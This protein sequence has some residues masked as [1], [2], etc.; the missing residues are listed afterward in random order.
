MTSLTLDNVL[1]CT[2]LPVLSPASV[3]LMDLT[4]DPD[5]QPD[6]VDTLLRQDPAL[7]Q[8]IVR[9]VN[10]RHF[11]PDE[12]CTTI[13]RAVTYL[14]MSPIR[15]LAAGFSLMDVTTGYADDIDLLEYWR[16]GLISAAAARYVAVVTRCCNPQDAFIAALMQ[17]IGML[18]LQTVVGGAYRDVLGGTDGNHR[19]LPRHERTVLGMTHAEAG[20]ALARQWKLPERMIEPI[21]RHHHRHA[22]ATINIPIVNAVVLGCQ[23]SHLCMG[24]MRKPD[25]ARAGAMSRRFF[26]LSSGDARMLLAGAAQDA[27][28]LAAGL[29][30]MGEGL[31]DPDVIMTRAS[32]AIV[33]HH[34]H[35]IEQA[36]SLKPL[37]SALAASAAPAGV[38]D[39][40]SFGRDLAERFAQARDRGACLGLILIAIDDFAALR[41]DRGPEAA[42]GV[43]AAVADTLR[44]GSTGSTQIGLY[45][46]G[47]LALLVPGASRFEAAKLAER[48]RQAIEQLEIDLGGTRDRVRVTACAGVA[49]RDAETVE[50]LVGAP[51]LL[52]LADG[53]LRSA[54]VAGPN[55]VRVFSP[56]SARSS[57]A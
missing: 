10:S 19:V 57:A 8:R 27:N 13:Q 38:G 53:A 4:L 21:L 36:A 55:C 47:T 46:P 1:A 31:L 9:A 34:C 5:A 2:R 24:G 32:E 39:R 7:A 26:G 30:V 12:P 18:A 49:A 37:Q 35:Q 14:G 33:V 43:L 45:E 54:R 23:I 15:S 16:R 28:R 42:N 51:Q 41:Y 3:E 48:K 6:D 22:G 20:A 29:A 44:E 11:G 50:K 25:V 52:Y 17:D 40:I 56:R